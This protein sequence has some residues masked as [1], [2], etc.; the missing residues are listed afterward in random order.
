[1]GG[2]SLLLP[3]VLTKVC[4]IASREISMVDLFRYPTVQ[5]LAAYIAAL[6]TPIADDQTTKQIKDKREAGLRR[7]KQ[8]RIQQAV[9][10]TE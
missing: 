1:L 4:A 2:H 9:T 8:R 5:A 6:P 3:K 7:M 10:R